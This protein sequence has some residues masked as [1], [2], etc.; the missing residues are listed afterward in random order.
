MPGHG[1]HDN[2]HHG[3]HGHHDHGHHGHGNHGHHEHHDNNPNQY[4]NQHQGNQGFNQGSNQ[5]FNQ[6]FN[7]GSNHVGWAPVQGAQYKI[8]SALASNMVLDVSQNQHDFNNL[9]IYQWGNGDNQ[10]FY[11]QSV[12]GNK[13]GIFSTKTHQT[14]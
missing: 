13:F 14:V 1:H 5:G 10:K 4:N 9:I 11:F 6:G 2:G 7:Q 3:H 8:V 12:G